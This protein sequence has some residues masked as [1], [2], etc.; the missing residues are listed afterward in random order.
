MT[1][2]EVIKAGAK[3]IVSFGVGSIVTNAVTFTTPVAAMGTLRRV[4]IGIGSFAMSAFA[5]EKIADYTDE[6]IDE[7]FAELD[8]MVTET[9]ETRRE[10]TA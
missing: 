5:S 2:K 6:K 10:A 7:A 1:K 8:Q 3:L 9:T 4:V